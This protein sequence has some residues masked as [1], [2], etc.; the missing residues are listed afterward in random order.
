MAR[1][2]HFQYVDFQQRVCLYE[3]TQGK[4]HD[5]LSLVQLLVLQAVCSLTVLQ[6]PAVAVSLNLL[7]STGEEAGSL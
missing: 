5:K 2:V 1:K 6:F 4:K 7:W 3:F